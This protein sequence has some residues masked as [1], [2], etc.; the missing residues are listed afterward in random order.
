MNGETTNFPSTEG[1]HVTSNTAI[2]NFCLHFVNNI[3]TYHLEAPFQQAVRVVEE[4][5]YTYGDANPNGPTLRETCITIHREKVAHAQLRHPIFATWTTWS[6][7]ECANAPQ[8]I[9]RFSS[10]LDN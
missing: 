4:E 1:I 6:D 7:A 5:P 9:P 10:V 2:H 3:C 8:T